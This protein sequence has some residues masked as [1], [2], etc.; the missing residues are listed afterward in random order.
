MRQE[1]CVKTY[2]F[3]APLVGDENVTFIVADTPQKAARARID[4]YAHP[5]GL[6]WVGV[7]ESGDEMLKGREPLYEKLKP[8]KRS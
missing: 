7:Y 8:V 6:Y 2:S 1:Y 5:F 4:N 3:P